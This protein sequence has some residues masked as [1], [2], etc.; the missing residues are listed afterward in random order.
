VSSFSASAGR[1]R[2]GPSDEADG[3]TSVEFI[4]YS[5]R[6]G[7]AGLTEPQGSARSNI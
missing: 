3:S 6:S 4:C 1:G 5:K 7:V 2:S